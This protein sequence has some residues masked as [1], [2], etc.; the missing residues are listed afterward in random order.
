MY[1]KGKRHYENFD[2]LQPPHL[3]PGGEQSAAVENVVPHLDH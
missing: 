2:V 3:H 1:I